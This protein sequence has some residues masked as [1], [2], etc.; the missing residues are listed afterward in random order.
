MTGWGGEGVKDYLSTS[1]WTPALL[2]SNI[3]ESSLAVPPFL[4]HCSC[5]ANYQLQQQSDHGL[6]EQQKCCLRS[7]TPH[8]D[9]FC[10]AHS[11]P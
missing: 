9:L 11:A 4:T 8:T 6:G 7:Q 3:Q 10:L 2:H 1:T 5:G